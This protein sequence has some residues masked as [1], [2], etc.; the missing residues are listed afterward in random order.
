MKSKLRDKPHPHQDNL[1]VKP[2]A[3]KS[4]LVNMAGW[5]PWWTRFTGQENRKP[6]ISKQS[7]EYIFKLMGWSAW[8]ARV[9][10]QEGRAVKVE[11]LS[12]LRQE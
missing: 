10:R 9:V 1:K 5:K 6:L 8:W 2:C 12:M 4:L 7:T 11:K 3:Q